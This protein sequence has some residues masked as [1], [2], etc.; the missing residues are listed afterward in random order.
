M[1]R[2]PAYHCNSVHDL[3]NTVESPVCLP[4]KDVHLDTLA[5]AYQRY[6]AQNIV[7]SLSSVEMMKVLGLQ[8]IL[9]AEIY[10]LELVTQ[11]RENVLFVGI[12]TRNI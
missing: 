8:G 5:F 2:T 6:I 11:K 9:T 4:H 1:I 3:L 10:R 12:L 7:S